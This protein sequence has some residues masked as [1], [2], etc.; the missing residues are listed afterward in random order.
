MMMNLI[1][2]DRVGDGGWELGNDAQDD[3]V[4]V[5][6]GGGEGYTTPS[7]EGGRVGR[8]CSRREALPLWP[9]SQLARILPRGVAGHIIN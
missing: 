8:S 5:G 3:K 6:G 1:G 7:R 9:G 4:T 2:N